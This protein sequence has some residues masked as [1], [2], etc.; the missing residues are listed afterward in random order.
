MFAFCYTITSL[1]L[2]NFNTSSVKEMQTLFYEDRNLE[3]I[4]FSN[5]KTN[6]LTNILEMFYG[7]S[8]LKYINLYSFKEINKIDISNLFNGASTDFIYCINDES[9]LPTIYQLLKSRN[10][11]CSKNCYNEL[12]YLNSNNQ[13]ISLCAQNSTFEYNNTCYSICPIR[14][15]ISPYNNHSCVDIICEKNFNYNQTSCLDY[16]PEGY[17]I[18]DTF[19]NTIDKCHHDCKTCKKGGDLISSNCESCYYPKILNFGNCVSCSN[20][21]FIDPKDNITKCICPYDTKCLLC[22]EIIYF[23]FKLCISCN[24]GYYPKINGPYIYNNSNNETF[25]DCYKDLEGYFL[26]NQVYKPCFWTCKNCREYGN[27]ANHKCLE[28]IASYEFQNDF[29]NINNCYEKCEYYYYY[30]DNVYNCTLEEKCPKEYNKLIKEKKRCIDYCT[31]D[32]IYKYEY[33]NSCYI[34]CP[35]GTSISNSNEYLCEK[36]NISECTAEEIF[37]NLC[38]KK[39]K[40]NENVNE[41]NDDKSYINKEEKMKEEDK[42]LE[43]IQNELSDGNL[44]NLLSDVIDGEKKDLTV[45]TETALYQFT[46]TENQNNNKNNNYSTINLGECEIKLKTHYNISFNES[47]LIFKID[48]FKSG[49]ITPTIEY[50][51][52]NSKTKDKFD[53]IHCKDSTVSL[54]IP[55]DIKEDQLFIYNETSEYYNDICFAFTTENGIDI[56]LNDR[57]NE[58]NSNNNLSLCETNCHYEGYDSKAKK[59]LCDCQIKIKMPLISEI[60]LNK[61]DLLK[62]LSLKRSLNIEVMKCYN[63]LFSKNGLIKNIGSYTI[64]LI[65][66]INIFLAVLFYIKDYNILHNEIKKIIKNK[67]NNNEMNEATIKKTKRKNSNY[68]S[69]NKKKSLTNNFIIKK[70]N[71]NININK[72]YKKDVNAP[73]KNKQKGINYMK[74]NENEIN[75]SKSNDLS[76]IGIASGGKYFLSSKKSNNKNN[77]KNNNKIIL[78]NDYELN[79]LPYKEAKKCDKRNYCQFYFSL[80][81]TKHVIIFTFL[82][83]NDYNSKVIKI[84]LFLFS[85]NLYFS[86]NGLFFSDSTMHKIYKDNGSYNFI[87]QMPLAIYSSLICSVINTLIKSLSL[88]QRNILAIKYLGNNRGLEKKANSMINC[89]KIKFRLFFILTF[90]ISILFW[91]Y[92]G[93]FC[94]VYKNTQ[95]HLIKDTLI[96]FGLSLI[97]PFWFYLFPGTFRIP[98]LNS[99]KNKELCYKFSKIIQS[100]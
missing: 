53:L 70:T 29:E 93:C 30:K 45:Q 18:N 84:S 34:S 72:I 97:Y 78:L 38:K 96:S 59:A 87:Y 14:T 19:L 7:C 74:T 89:L 41:N 17:F 98:S 28:C 51:V 69:K 8:K 82:Q 76:K 58:F 71:K 56:S 86:V 32:N 2:S 25:I 4:N 95:L 52:Y 90:F 44:D 99:K 1:D 22:N 9:N 42:F 43:N 50:E 100:I 65:I 73:P 36:M 88:S 11:D 12:K 39:E 75:N 61:D 91:Y 10:R 67:K 83:N 60:V 57:K 55:V 54:A 15:K 47:L 66:F 3:Y 6:S 81:K 80:L 62:S 24:N 85:F 13:C 49:H 77:Q 31:N 46:T 37:S 5:I 48:V 94:A 20:G 16:I 21:H 92:L 79:I 68:I 23:N 33:N 27:E 63:L 64:M 26:E 35:N 40:I